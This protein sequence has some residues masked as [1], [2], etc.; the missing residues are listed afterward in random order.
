MIT[1]RK[2]LIVQSLVLLAGTVFAWSN[3]LPQISRFQSLYETLFKFTDCTVPNP[4]LTACFFGSF[5]F[6]I[7]LLWSLSIYRSPNPLRERRLRNFLLFCVVFATSVIVYEAAQYYKLIA[8]AVSISCNPGAS[9]FTTPCF[10]GDIF[11]IISLSISILT[12]QQFESLQKLPPVRSV[13]R[14]P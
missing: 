8:S 14:H 12:I 13:A 3:F 2:F 7:A 6:L 5:A 10:Y 11:F 9:P 1:T 4:L